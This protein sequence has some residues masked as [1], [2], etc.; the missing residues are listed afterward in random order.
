M[1]RNCRILL[2]RTDAELYYKAPETWVEA[3]GE[4]FDFKESLKAQQCCKENKFNH[5][6][7]L[8]DFGNPQYD[9]TLPVC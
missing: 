3:R 1:Q 6:V 7:V 2:K 8:M 4:A 5:S 9:V